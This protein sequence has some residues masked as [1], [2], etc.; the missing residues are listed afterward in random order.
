MLGVAKGVVQMIFRIK[1]LVRYTVAARDGALGYVEDFYFDEFNWSLRYMV[2]AGEDE[3][4]GRK[5]LLSTVALDRPDF[6]TS[7]MRVKL[8]K[9]TIKNSPEVTFERALTR[10]E[11]V[12]LHSYYQ[13]PFYWEAAGISAYPFV[14]MV[15]E[16]RKQQAEND[17]IRNL[18]SVKKILG[19]SIQ[20][21]DGDIGS[22]DDFLVEDEKW[23]MHYLV[24]DTGSWLPGRKVIISPQWIEEI[25]WDEAGV[26]VDLN[27]ETIKNSPEYDPSVPLD[28]EYEK[29]LHEYYGR[30]RAR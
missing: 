17:E 27:R 30:K 9:E 15:S 12:A 10:E 20:A 22:V 24:I 13:W 26:G 19:L 6:T 14:E 8:L 21:R 16:M 18:R 1:E 4:D 29:R 3:L 23:N 5:F 7:Q 11:E 2:V 28:T 25:R